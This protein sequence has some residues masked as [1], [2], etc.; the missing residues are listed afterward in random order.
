MST[1]DITDIIFARARSQNGWLD[2][3]V[4]DATLREL[5]E[6]L[7]WGPTSV[8]CSPARFVFLRTEQAR[9]KLKPALAP[10]NIDKTLSAPVVVIVGYDTCFHEHLPDLFP[11]NPAVKT[12]FAGDE[13]REFAHLTAFR[14]GTLQGAYLIA[15][16][17]A[18]GLDCGLTAGPCPV[19]TM[20]RSTLCSLKARR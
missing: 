3:P 4:S 13:K 9:E 8:N 17:R 20:R 7:K 19:S 11:H 18:I 5:Y 14:N 2:K 1:T 6:H 10:G 15:A 12:W 16:A